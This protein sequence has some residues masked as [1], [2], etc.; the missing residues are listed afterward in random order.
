MVLLGLLKLA[1]IWS[2]IFHSRSHVDWQRRDRCEA[3][4]S[5]C[6]RV[7][8]AGLA[9]NRSESLLQ[10]LP[11][12]PLFK[13]QEEAG[14]EQRSKPVSLTSS[15]E[16]IYSIC[17]IPIM[18][19]CLSTPPFREALSWALCHRDKTPHQKDGRKQPTCNSFIGLLPGAGE[20]HQ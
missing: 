20:P 4:K 12:L 15:T 16:A 8:N 3:D 19:A 13:A 1:R 11:S 14:K 5:V 2:F 7:L 10:Y 17:A 9:A 18:G 6:W